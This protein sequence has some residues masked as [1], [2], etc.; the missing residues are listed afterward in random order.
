MSDLDQLDYYALLGVDE[1]A[2]IVMVNE[3]FRVFT[4]TKRPAS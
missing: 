1:E 2:S 4:F 3:A